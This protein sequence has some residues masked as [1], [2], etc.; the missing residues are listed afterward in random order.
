ME[1]ALL[2]LKPDI[3]KMESDIKYRLEHE[4]FKICNRKN[5]QLSLYQITE[6]YNPDEQETIEDTETFEKT[7]SYMASGPC[8]VYLLR[9]FN[10]LNHLKE[11]IGPTDPYEAREISPQSLRAIYAKNKIHN[12]FHASETEYQ[13]LREIRF[14]FPDSYIE[15]YHDKETTMLFLEKQVYP[16]LLKGLVELAKEK[17]S[18]PTTWLGKWLLANHPNK[19][20]VAI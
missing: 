19:P 10:A 11:L 13:C 14:F 6:F 18:D 5:I 2:I 7:R 3:I 9:K 20:S 15:P 12:G 16:V 8:V 1:Q 4:G 17:P